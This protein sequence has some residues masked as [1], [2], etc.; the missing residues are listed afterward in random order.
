MTSSGDPIP[1][2]LAVGR[3]SEVLRPA[4]APEPITR[5]SS[6]ARRH[7]GDPRRAFSLQMRRLIVPRVRK[8]VGTRVARFRPMA[9]TISECPVGT[10]VSSGP[11]ATPADSSPHD[12]DVPSP[13][14]VGVRV[15]TRRT[16]CTKCESPVF[17]GDLGIARAYV[18]RNSG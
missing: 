2:G 13:S 14:P 18:L 16:S 15:D 4:T 11:S 1:V 10:A 6:A 12:P 9:L 3:C 8:P 5:R 17:T 7:F